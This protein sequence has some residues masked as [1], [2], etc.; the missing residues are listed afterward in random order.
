MTTKPV[1]PR[2]GSSRV[3]F[4]DTPR[5]DMQNLQFLNDPAFIPTL[6]QHLGFWDTTA[7]LSEY[8]IGWRNTR[9]RRGLLV[10]DLLI[11]FGVD[12]SVIVADNGYSIEY[13]GKAPD[14][15]LEIASPT[16]SRRDETEKRVGYEAFGVPEYWRFDNTGGQHY[17][18]PLAGDRLVNGAYEP[19]PVEEVSW[20]RRW[21]YSA[22]LGLYLCW[23]YGYLRWYDPATG[24]LP[25]H[26]QVL[27]AGKA[28]ETERLAAEAE[29]DRELERRLAAEARNRE[30]EA[31]IQRLRSL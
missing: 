26:Y 11:A 6:R 24:Y 1:A 23:E 14:F 30:L 15:V 22:A 27:D 18:T 28:A 4:P 17:S 31:E 9:E 12:P 13:Q 10:P 29:R 25:T 7:V 20:A 16:T 21:G 19:I 5:E 3:L 8:P 2:A